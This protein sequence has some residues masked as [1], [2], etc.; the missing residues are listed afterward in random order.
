M[1]VVFDFHRF[2]HEVN[3]PVSF[4]DAKQFHRVTA[5]IV[6]LAE[7]ILFAMLLRLFV[8]DLPWVGRLVRMIWPVLVVVFCMVLYA[9]TVTELHTI[10]FCPRSMVIERR[11]HTVALSYYGAG[12]MALSPLIAL[13]ALATDFVPQFSIVTIVLITLIGLTCWAVL[14]Y[15]VLKTARRSAVEV[16]LFAITWPVSCAAMAGVTLALIPMCAWHIAVIL[17]NWG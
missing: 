8:D 9:L 15:L 17:V 5:G 12:P 7:L 6:F 11:N 1:M 3:K 4:A 13:S 10:W 14:V 16:V 2:C